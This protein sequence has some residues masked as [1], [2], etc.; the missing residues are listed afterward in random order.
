[1]SRIGKGFWIWLTFSEKDQIDLVKLQSKVQFR[2]NSPKFK[3]H[4]TLCGPYEIMSE[5]L[6]LFVKDIANKQ[7]NF[8]LETNKYGKKKE[9]FE[10][11][12][13]RI[14]ESQKL[15]DLRKQFSKFENKN[16]EFQY[17][18]HISLSYGVFENK[19]KNDLILTLPEINQNLEVANIAIVKV[20]ENKFLWDE[21]ISFPLK[22]RN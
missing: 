4:L 1:M 6:V 5:E 22:N 8:V 17:T 15:I 19:V 21:V 9:F 7:K 20:D 10:S 3:I 2:L 13:I 12:F 16:D 14:K 18:P 11:F